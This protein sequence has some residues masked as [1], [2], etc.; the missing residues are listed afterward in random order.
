MR[1]WFWR[2]LFKTYPSRE[3]GRCKLTFAGARL[4][5]G[6]RVS[7]KLPTTVNPDVALDRC[8]RRAA[9]LRT[10]PCSHDGR[11]IR[12]R[13][14]IKNGFR[15]AGYVGHVGEH[16]GVAICW[17]SRASSFVKITGLFGSLAPPKMSSSLPLKSHWDNVSQ[18]KPLAFR[19]DAL[20]CERRD[21]TPRH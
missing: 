17:V 14:C 4:P 8:A 11:R 3:N 15:G 1:I 9:G 13:R 19:S 16:I 6:L 21:I 5:H 2:G 12:L 10:S 20:S 7:A 18:E